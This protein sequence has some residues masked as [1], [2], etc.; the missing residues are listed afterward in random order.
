MGVSCAQ[1]YSDVQ[2]QAA[3]PEGKSVHEIYYGETP[4]NDQHLFMRPAFCK[5]KRKNKAQPNAQECF[6]L[7]PAP[8]V[9]A[10]KC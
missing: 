6:Y 9:T 10:R 8:N 4:P 3:N 2:R 5:M 1:L 7:G